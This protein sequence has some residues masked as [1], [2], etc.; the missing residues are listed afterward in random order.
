MTLKAI[1]TAL[2]LLAAVCFPVQAD[3]SSAKEDLKIIEAQL[4]KPTTLYC[5]CR[6][7]FKSEDRYL[8]ELNSCGYAVRE[9]K[10]RA[11]RIEAEHI[12]PTYVFGHTLSCW[13]N[14][15]KGQGRAQCELISP[16]FDR[17]ESDL[18]NLYP[19][20]GEVNGDRSNYAFTNS[21]NSGSETFSYGRCEMK[22]S[23]K[24]GEAVPPDR[25]K[26]IIARA[27]LYMSQRYNLALTVAEEKLFNAWNDRFRPDKNECRRNELIELVQ[28]NDNPFITEKCRYLS[29]RQ[30]KSPLNY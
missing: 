10:I 14:A 17:M 29:L 15:P 8:P 25:A 16:L 1:P 30:N 27:Y 12:V 28:G 2:T 23:P 21:I 18:H 5:G 13:A 7:V 3:F 20:I 24:L 26:G 9:D 4:D 6:L 11:N 19:T 22:I